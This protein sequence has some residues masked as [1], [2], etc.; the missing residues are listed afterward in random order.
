MFIAFWPFWSFIILI[1]LLG[2]YVTL[3]VPPIQDMACQEIGYE[4]FVNTGKD[5]LDFCRDHEGN[6]HYIDWGY[7]GFMEVWVKEISVGDVRVVE[8]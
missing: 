7:D 4:K 1:V 8:K 3:V 6:L 5:G 2:L